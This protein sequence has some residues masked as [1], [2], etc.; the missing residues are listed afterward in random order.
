M[1]WNTQK[2]LHFLE[3]GKIA[4]QH[5]VQKIRCKEV[6]FKKSANYPE[7]EGRN[8]PQS[9]SNREQPEIMTGFC[10]CLAGIQSCQECFSQE[11]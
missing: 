1:P 5:A 8:C 2:M 6:S 7:Y 10:I 4:I 11:P 9:G 3:S